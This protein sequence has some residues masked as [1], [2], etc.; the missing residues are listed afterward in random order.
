MTRDKQK[1]SLYDF[2]QLLKY[3]FSEFSLLL[4]PA[5]TQPPILLHII[6]YFKTE[7]FH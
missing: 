7:T 1:S 5:H 6:P 3:N 2:D 4:V